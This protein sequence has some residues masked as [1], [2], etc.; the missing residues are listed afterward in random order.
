[1]ENLKTDMIN[2]TF[3]MIFGA[4]E[5]DWLKLR[6]EVEDYGRSVDCYVV[7]LKEGNPRDLDGIPV[8]ALSEISAEEKAGVIIV[9]NSL[10]RQ[11]EIYAL[12]KREGFQNIFY[13]I[14]RYGDLSA[15]EKL[16]IKNSGWIIAMGEDMQN[17]S[18]AGRTGPL[19][20]RIYVV[21]SHS[22]L[23]R[24][25]QNLAS[26]IMCYIQ[27]GSALTEEIICE[28]KDNTGDHISEKN[29]YFCE[30]TAGY[31]I[32]K[33][34]HQHDYVGLY[35]YSRGFD[36]EEKEIFYFLNSGVQ[37]ILSEPLVCFSKRKNFWDT[38]VQIRKAIRHI[39]PEYIETYD[40]YRKEGLFIPSNMIIAK[41]EIFDQY[42]QWLFDIFDEYEKYLKKLG[43]Q[44]AVRGM[45]YLA[46]ELTGVYFLH[47]SNQWKILYVKQREF[48]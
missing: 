42:Y 32:Y 7:S 43:L 9:S 5:Q 38:E 40:R 11:E 31:W 24:A 25:N 45:G 18:D 46:E 44:V 12:L 48:Y 37:V 26:N 29:R 41:K 20:I 35:H 33:N 47:H 36:L 23:H 2:A 19:H 39:Y 17:L 22:N 27:A 21:T 4:G 8:R 10:G 30:L 3:V 34:D 13:G 28:L 16:S 6:A 15:I 14:R 1:M